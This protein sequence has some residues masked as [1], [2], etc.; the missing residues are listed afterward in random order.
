MSTAPRILALSVSLTAILAMSTGS[1]DAADWAAQPLSVTEAGPGTPRWRAR[2]FRSVEPRYARCEL[3]E[4][5]RGATPLTVPFFGSG[6]YP[7]PA[8]Y[9]GPPGCAGAP[10]G[11]GH[12]GQI[13][14]GWRLGKLTSAGR[15]LSDLMGGT[16]PGSHPLCQRNCLC[17]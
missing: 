11:C 6:W 1:T 3:V 13:L 5:V 17:G 16:F 15:A 4:G 8:Y 7:G 2:P 14:D 12:F 10:R 9:Y